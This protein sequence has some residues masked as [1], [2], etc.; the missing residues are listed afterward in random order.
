MQT[1]Q[2]L[3]SFLIFT[4]IQLPAAILGIPLVLMALLT[5]WDGR[6]YFF[7]NS[8]WGRATHHYLKPTKN[9]YWREFTWLALRNP[10]YNLDAKILAVEVCKHVV[11]G[12][13]L[14]GDKSKGGKYT[15]R[16]GKYWEYYSILPYTILNSKRCV[17]LR[18]GWKINGVPP[19]EKAMWV[20][21]FNPFKTY[22][23]E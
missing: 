9:N 8:K 16:M 6:R 19:Y 15:I 14:I 7:G 18:F 1:L 3:V 22:S 5:P 23:G 12:D 17:R 21:S 20:F 13:P 4:F 10:V 11:K 2:F